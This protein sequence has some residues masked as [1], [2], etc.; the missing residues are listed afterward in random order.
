[1]SRN[2]FKDIYNVKFIVKLGETGSEVA[3]ML[4]TV[5]GNETTRS[6]G[7]YELIKKFREETYDR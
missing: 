4:K 6:A 1:M 2:L 7:V 3:E 5:H